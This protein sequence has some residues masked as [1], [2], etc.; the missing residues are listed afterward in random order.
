MARRRLQTSPLALAICLHVLITGSS[1][2]TLHLADMDRLPTPVLAASAAGITPGPA[3]DAIRLR[4][5]VRSVSVESCARQCIA[6]AI[7]KS[8]GCQLGDYGCECETGNAN[9]I[10]AGSFAC[11][12]A[13]CGAILAESMFQG[14][15]L[16]VSSWACC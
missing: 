11:V 8:T 6:N 7:T 16:A 1:A 13:A 12:E 3:L 2:V 4:L 15:F 5:E 10:A 14:A 9:A